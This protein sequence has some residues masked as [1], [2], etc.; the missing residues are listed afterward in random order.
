M[1]TV[2]LVMVAGLVVL[3]EHGTGDARIGLI[4]FELLIAGW[5]R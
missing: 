2:K 5:A 1:V 3:I 4:D